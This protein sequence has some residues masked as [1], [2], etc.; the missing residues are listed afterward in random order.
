MVELRGPDLTGTE[1]IPSSRF[2]DRFARQALPRQHEIRPRHK[3]MPMSTIAWSH[4]MSGDAR[5]SLELPRVFLNEVN[6]REGKAQQ[7]KAGSEMWRKRRRTMRGGLR[8]R[9]RHEG[10]A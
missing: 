10:R 3:I 2:V 7:S 1:G 6:A 4:H 5:P 8:C 9:R